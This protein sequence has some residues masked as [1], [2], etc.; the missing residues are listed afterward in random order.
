MTIQ[1]EVEYDSWHPGIT[2]AL[3]GRNQNQPTEK[4]TSEPQ[5]IE[6]LKA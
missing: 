6:H 5:T 1:E 3:H 2:E 4:L